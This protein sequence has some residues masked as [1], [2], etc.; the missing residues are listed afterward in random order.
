MCDTKTIVKFH[1]G[2]MEIGGISN[3]HIDSSLLKPIDLD[4]VRSKCFHRGCCF[5]RTYVS[6]SE[7][8]KIEKALPQLNL[9]PKV[10]EYLEG[11]NFYKSDNSIRLLSSKSKDI[12]TCIFLNN[13]N[14]IIE[15]VLP[16]QCKAYPVLIDKDVLRL[17]YDKIPCL[18]TNLYLFSWD[19]IPGYDNESLIRFLSQT[20]DINWLETAKIEKF[21]T[22]PDPLQW[23][24][25][26]TVKLTNGKN[27]LSL[28]LKDN[29]VNLEI[30]DGRTYEF[31]M[32][33]EN[34]KQNI[35]TNSIP[36]YIILEKEISLL[37]SSFDKDFYK[38]LV[39]FLNKKQE[40]YYSRGEEIH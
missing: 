29:K 18:S 27:F 16:A 22:N 14:C 40:E 36:A 31:I 24:E 8:E 38:K 21:N 34:G 7:I 19:G 1:S 11:F 10:R 39:M 30:D 33:N 35:Y 37:T 2:S 3:L 13:R 25:D 15:S 23:R 4:C 9:P 5:C 26:E 6:S 32:K 20:F 28:R 17:C 12:P